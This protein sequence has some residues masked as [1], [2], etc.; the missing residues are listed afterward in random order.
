MTALLRG[1]LWKGDKWR[2]ENLDSRWG[3]TSI[4]APTPGA[5]NQL[6]SGLPTS[7]HEAG[8]GSDCEGGP[9]SKRISST[10][11]IRPRIPRLGQSSSAAKKET[12]VTKSDKPVFIYKP[13]S[14]TFLRDMAALGNPQL[15][16]ESLPEEYD[17]SNTPY[18]PRLIV[19]KNEGDELSKE[20]S[21]ASRCSSPF[22]NSQELRDMPHHPSYR[23][24]ISSPSPSLRSRS[25]MR[26][27]SS[28]SRRNAIAPPS[29]TRSLP[30][31][32]RVSPRP[33]FAPVNYGEPLS[34]NSSATTLSQIPIHRVNQPVRKPANMKAKSHKRK[35]TEEMVPSSTE[36]FG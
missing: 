3:D 12:N 36:L 13:A 20:L 22:E 9:P 5:W 35:V 11:S 21:E 30:A 26:S 14:E 4:S 17:Y 6:S 15:Q 27:V 2:S 34:S 25:S 24:F 29:P 16:L 18:N 33:E 19:Y 31:S 10:K 1:C 8:Y 23:S 7:G 32:P 28:R